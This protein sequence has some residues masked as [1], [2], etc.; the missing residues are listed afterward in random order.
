MSI[1]MQRV[2]IVSKAVK[3][4]YPSCLDA[5]GDT[6]PLSGLSGTADT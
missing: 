4:D 2:R 5:P 6:L 3:D 1:D